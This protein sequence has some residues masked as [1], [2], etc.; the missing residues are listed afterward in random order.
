LTG[1]IKQVILNINNHLISLIKTDFVTYSVS[2]AEI[3]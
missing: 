2:Y 3:S 1:A